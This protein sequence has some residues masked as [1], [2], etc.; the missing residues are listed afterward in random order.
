MLRFFLFSLLLSP[1]ICVSASPENRLS[2]PSSYQIDQVNISLSHQTGHRLPGSYQINISG[3]LDAMKV[4]DQ[5]LKEEVK[6]SES[7][8]IELLNEFYQIHF[9][10]FNDTYTVQ[11]SVA[12]LDEGK[13]ETFKRKTMDMDS[14]R[15]C[16]SITDYKKCVTIMGSQPS[17]L[18][19]LV[20]KIEMLFIK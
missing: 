5:N 12:L 1:L 8:F 16:L 4:V 10:E 20:K 7:V 14:Q 9:F 15:M 17:D 3:T 11:T 6:L 2:P 19:E 13:I 18:K